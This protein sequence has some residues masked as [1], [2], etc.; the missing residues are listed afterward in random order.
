LKKSKETQKIS[1]RSEGKRGYIATSI[2]TCISCG[3]IIPEG[4]LV[5]VQC[6]LAWIEPRCEICG[7]TVET[8][9]AICKSCEEMLL[10]AKNKK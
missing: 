9:N 6:E 5:C 10:H 2:N 3:A 7:K 4:T 8:R 1:Q